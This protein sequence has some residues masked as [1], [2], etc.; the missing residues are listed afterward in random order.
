MEK[1]ASRDSIHPFYIEDVLKAYVAYPQL[2]VVE[3]YGAIQAN[4]GG[5]NLALEKLDGFAG[6][7]VNFAAAE[8]VGDMRF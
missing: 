3:I 4:H 7:R 2:G 5:F 6:R 1:D 8:D